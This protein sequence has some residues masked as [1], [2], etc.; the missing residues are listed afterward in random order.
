[1]VMGNLLGTGQAL[2]TSTDTIYS[3]FKL[4]RDESGSFRS[5]ATFNPLKPHEGRSKNIN[6][7]GRVVAYDLADGVDMQQAQQLSDTTS[8]YTPNEVG[9]QV[10][11]PGSTLRRGADQSMLKRVSQMM[12]NAYD[13]K[14]DQDG[15]LQMVNFTPIMGVAGNI[16]GVG[17]YFGG[18][19]RLMIGNN[20]SNPEPPPKPYFIIDHPLKLAALAGRMLPMGS[21]SAGGSVYTPATVANNLT[22]GPSYG[23]GNSDD[24]RKQH[25]NA[26]GMLFGCTVKHSANLIP[27][28]N[29]DVSGGIFSQEGLLYV[30]ELE[31]QNDPDDSDKSLRGAIELNY[32]GSYVWG[33]WRPAAYGVEI[34]GDASLPAA[35]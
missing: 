12:N 23:D 3:G 28:A 2:D 8:I 9:V 15:G 30:S 34:L 5:A 6:N 1:M 7:Y 10:V 4:L 20:R 27:D 13:L 31:P 22:V 29:D 16:L 24:I 17:E 25:I 33:T 26:L 21:T 19:S 35:S 32:W 14:E 11:I 18:V